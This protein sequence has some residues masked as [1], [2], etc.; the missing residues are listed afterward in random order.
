[1]TNSDG[2]SERRAAAQYSTSCDPPAH[3]PLL[4]VFRFT[5][6]AGHYHQLFTI[7][8]YHVEHLMD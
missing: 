5:T 3:H 4:T 6:H 8:I 1:M 2:D 7:Y